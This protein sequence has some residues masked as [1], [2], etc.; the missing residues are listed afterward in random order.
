MAAETASG[1][2]RAIQPG[3]RHV[4]C[5]SLR[6]QPG[7]MLEGC[8]R[9]GG[10]EVKS[11]RI[12][13]RMSSRSPRILEVVSPVFND[14]HAAAM[15]LEQLDLVAAND[16]WSWRVLLV[17]DGSTDE[18]PADSAF[19]PLRAIQRV[20]I[21][22][23][24]RNLGHQRAI[25][26]GLAY[27]AAHNPCE[28]VLVMDS[29]GEDSPSDVPRLLDQFDRDDGRKV[30]FAER[31]KRSEGIVFRAFY[32][33]YRWCHLLLTGVAVRVGN[34]SVMPTSA[35][36]RLVTAADLWNHYAA[37]VFNTRIPFTSVPT[38]RSSRY[39]GQSRMG[40]VSLVMHGLSAIAVF[41]DRV[42]VRLLLGGIVL[43]LLTLVGL[44]AAVVIRLT[45]SLAIPGWAT[46]VVGFLVLAQVQIICS[47]VVFVFIVQGNR[48]DLGF[49]PA[50]DHALFVADLRAL[51]TA[52]KPEKIDT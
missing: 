46:T 22:R 13:P 14:W 44:A 52:G 2:V 28:A 7:R 30:V 48:S 43:L 38:L 9:V 3:G 8:P 5:L 39:S 32:L 36:R 47:A 25:A 27:T 23:L 45:T 51:P 21:L 37:T 26:I 10:I 31:T 20:S 15:L 50:R 33:L 12:Q 6:R 4:M 16:D 40:F 24:T 1:G 42:A 18:P 29:D 35:L 49:L 41:R 34:F 17:D 11:P 19:P